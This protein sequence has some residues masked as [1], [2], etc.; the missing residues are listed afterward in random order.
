MDHKKKIEYARRIAKELE[1]DKTL[2]SLKS[3]LKSEGLYDRDISNIMG[4]ARNIL[5]DTY[6]PKIREFLLDG[7]QIQGAEE[8]SSLDSDLLE[9][10]IAKESKNIASG[11]RRKITKLVKKGISAEEI[12]NQIDTRFLPLENATE[13]IAQHEEV[14]YQ[15]SGS[16]RIISIVSGI[17]LIVFTV[18]VLYASGRLFYFLPI[19]GLVMIVRGLLPQRME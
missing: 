9:T 11:E 19:I 17:G 4:S 13:Q 6:Q 12:L 18:I 8:F 5:G 16:G 15:N 2:E 14:K 3:D 10:L 7:K 1:G